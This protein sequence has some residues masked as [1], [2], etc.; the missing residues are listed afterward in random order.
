MRVKE[1]QMFDKKLFFFKA[2][3]K[4]QIKFSSNKIE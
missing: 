1:E 2:L 4:M 3:A